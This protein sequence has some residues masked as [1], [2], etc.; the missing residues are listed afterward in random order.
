MSRTLNLLTEHSHYEE[1]KESF[2]GYER[3][4]IIMILL[5]LG[6]YLVYS[7]GNYAMTLS[8]E[9]NLRGRLS[10]TTNKGTPKDH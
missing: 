5:Q 4:V 10:I 3:N 7:L 1:R 8:T 6:Y 2:I 9:N